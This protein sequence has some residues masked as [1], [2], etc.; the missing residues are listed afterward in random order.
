MSLKIPLLATYKKETFSFMLREQTKQL[1]K[2]KMFRNWRK[3]DHMSFKD[4]LRR[5]FGIKSKFVAV[6]FVSQVK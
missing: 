3:I 4:C 6:N 2:E 1:N 5:L